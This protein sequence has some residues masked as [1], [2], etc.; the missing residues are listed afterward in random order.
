[1]REYVSASKKQQAKKKETKYPK[2][3][4]QRVLQEPLIGVFGLFADVEIQSQ[5]A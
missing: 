1:M 3:S 4:S 2:T 5:C